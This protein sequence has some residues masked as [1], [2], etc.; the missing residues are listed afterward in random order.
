MALF[1]QHM[2]HVKI[3]KYSEVEKRMK[4]QFGDDEKKTEASHTPEK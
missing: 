3:E 4:E 1:R 2:Q